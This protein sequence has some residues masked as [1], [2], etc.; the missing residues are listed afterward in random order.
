M[1]VWERS[2]RGGGGTRGWGGAR[3]WER[4]EGVGWS[5][6]VGSSKEVGEERGGRQN[7][8][9]EKRSLKVRKPK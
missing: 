1:R 2:E 9:F 8:E 5:E 6:G 4:S 3:V 7:L